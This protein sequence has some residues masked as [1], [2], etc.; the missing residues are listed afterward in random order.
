M[1]FMCPS[2]S[3]GVLVIYTPK[4]FKSSMYKNIMNNKV[5][6]AIA[7]N[8]DCNWYPWPK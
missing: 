6:K 2:D 4:Y 7:K 5:S 3:F 1:Y 8:P